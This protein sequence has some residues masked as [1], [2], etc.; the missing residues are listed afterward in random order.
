MKTTAMVLTPGEELWSDW[1]EPLNVTVGQAAQALGISRKTLSHIINGSA[2][3]TPAMSVRLSKA[4]GTAPDAWARKQLAF[5]LS[6]V[7]PK[8]LKVRRLTP[9][10]YRE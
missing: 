5:D 10:G 9:R 3:I 2:R 6:E 4:L 1:L 8:T 7:D